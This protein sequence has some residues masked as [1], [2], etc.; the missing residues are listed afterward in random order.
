MSADFQSGPPR[1]PN[2]AERR[3]SARIGVVHK[4]VL[5]ISL[6]FV[7]I[8]AVHGY[9]S[10]RSELTLLER[11]MQRDLELLGD[12]VAEAFVQ[13]WEE[14]GREPALE[15]ISHADQLGRDVRIRWRS[16][17][18]ETGRA[19][20][21]GVGSVRE[22]RY[23]FVPV[24]IAGE[25]RGHIEISESLES[26]HAYARSRV[27]RIVLVTLA[28]MVAS[29]VV[30]T[31]LGKRL[32]GARLG[33]LM[34][35]AQQIGSGNFERRV[36]ISGSDEIAALERQMNTMSAML[37]EARSVAERS[38]ADRV[39][40]LNQLR[41]IDRIA[42]VGR[43][44]SSLAHE[45]GTPLQTIM[46][47]A[48]RI[49]SGE[50]EPGAA[51]EDARIIGEQTRRMA[52]TIRETL[53]FIRGQASETTSLDLREVV[54]EGL[55]LIEPLATLRGIHVRCTGLEN[56]LKVK[57][58]RGELIQVLTNLIVNALDAM[59]KGGSVV[60]VELVSVSTRRQGREAL[61]LAPHACLSVT[62]QGQ[63]IP[64][65]ELP[66]IFEPSF[67][68]KQDGAGTGLGLW[69]VNGIVS[70][71]GGWIEVESRPG[72]GARFSVLLPACEA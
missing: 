42:S 34:E 41:A 27:L 65:A 25:L 48:G 11:D 46:G 33:D 63:G 28:L 57:A 31:Q 68:T 39:Q 14:E 52:D 56:V 50:V 61:P 69:L 13:V 2:Q 15:I 71:H 35:H 29:F 59:E 5:A 67:T 20:G 4:L 49:E 36:Q 51:A 40:A 21:N 19:Q 23:H 54:L 18:R 47:R 45:L 55:R 16:S 17:S 60:E 70:D 24:R 44:A 3:R 8:I 38:N 22:R 53:R 64:E 43:V 9:F 26:L 30:A 10:V 6:G 7:P 12:V 72:Q 37:E 62:D 66:R 1:D 58:R 32:V